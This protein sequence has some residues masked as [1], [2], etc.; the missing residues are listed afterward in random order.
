MRM[1]QYRYCFGS[2]AT[3]DKSA[4]LLAFIREYVARS[5]GVAPSFREM[6]VGIGV[7]ST[8]HVSKLVRKLEAE[9]KIRCLP[10]KA[11]AMELVRTTQYF[12]VERI[13]GQARLLPMRKERVA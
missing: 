3:G 2:Q 5:G 11:R 12:K 9:G 1:S 6:R 13:N 7:K 10:G 4:K 8:G